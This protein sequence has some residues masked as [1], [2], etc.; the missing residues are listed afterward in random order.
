M[1][2]EKEKAYQREYHKLYQ[3]LHK[4]KLAMY[5]LEKRRAAG[6]RP[7]QL[8]RMSPEEK[9]S[10]DKA[11]REANQEAIKARSAKY[12]AENKDKIKEKEAARRNVDREAYNAKLRE[13]AREVYHADVEVARAKE[14]AA[15]AIRQKRKIENTLTDVFSAAAKASRS[16]EARKARQAKEKARK[17][18]QERVRALR[19]EWE[20]AN[21]E[22]IKAD[23]KAY[24]RAWKDANPGKRA[25]HRSSRKV[26]EKRAT[27]IW[28]DFKAMAAVYDEC[29]WIT[30]IIGELH[31]VDHIVPLNSPIV[32]GLNWEGNLQILTAEENIAKSN[33]H[34]PDMP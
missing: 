26:V 21:A 23:R 22:K 13:K 30:K 24:N 34:W 10:R 14:R 1:I 17:E 31:H 2:S 18:N 28:A 27:P 7:R 20:K 32:C 8:G 4:E 19:L 5:Q 29:I 6:I 11:Y 9:R 15:Y 12:Y 16:E 3:K 25:A 33:R